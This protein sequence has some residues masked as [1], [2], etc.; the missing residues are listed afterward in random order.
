MQVYTTRHAS[1]ERYDRLEYIID[2]VGFGERIILE[3]FIPNEEKITRKIQITDSGVL[4]VKPEKEE[5][6]I[7]AW[8]ASIEQAVMVA[9]K[10]GLTHVP[11][12]LYKKVSRNKKYWKNQP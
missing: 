11:E 2:T 7:T 8:I 3:A 9:R 6:I 12:S 5:I 1:V 10:S 4:L